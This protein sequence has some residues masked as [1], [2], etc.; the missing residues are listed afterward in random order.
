MRVGQLRSGS[1]PAC[2]ATFLPRPRCGLPALFAA[3]SSDDCSGTGFTAGR[4]IGSFIVIY[5][6][7][8]RLLRP[9][10]RNRNLNNFRI[11]QV[12]DRSHTV[13]YFR[14]SI[15]SRQQLSEPNLESKDTQ[16]K[17]LMM[18]M[19][20]MVGYMMAANAANAGAPPPP[21][22]DPNCPWIR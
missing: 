7:I 12:F 3:S 22:C 4:H 1:P 18:V 20:L 19:T 15:D 9:C 16:M 5:R 14:I 11:P 13:G 17:K 8:R 21:E 2:G 6:T 10:L